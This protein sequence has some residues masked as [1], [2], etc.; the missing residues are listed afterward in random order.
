MR[1]GTY[2]AVVDRIEDGLATLQVEDDGRL[3]DELTVEPSTLPARARRA[4]AVV[5]VEIV[6]DAVAAAWYD[7]RETAARE[8]A[9]QDRFDRL[10][11]RPPREGESEADPGDDGDA[12][13]DGASDDG[14]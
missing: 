9:T 11:R 4:D 7:P 14:R 3:L 12:E 5:R 1:D 10:S 8:R 6:A 13:R 2:T